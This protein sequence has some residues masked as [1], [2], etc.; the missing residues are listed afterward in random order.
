MVSC[1]PVMLSPS[2]GRWLNSSRRTDAS[3]ASVFRLTWGVA[4]GR[5]RGRAKGLRGSSGRMETGGRARVAA[6]SCHCAASSFMPSSKSSIKSVYCG[7][8][9]SCGAE[10]SLRS[11]GC[12]P[13]TTNSPILRDSSS[14]HALSS[15][16]DRSC[17][18]TGRDSEWTTNSP[19]PRDSWSIQFGVSGVSG[20]SGVVGCCVIIARAN[21]LAE[22][23]C[24][25]DCHWSGCGRVSTAV[26]D[27]IRIGG[28]P[29]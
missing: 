8:N 4:G 18:E 2:S 12:S 9:S 1:S 10:N 27:G 7:R 28:V 15:G 16:W 26:S 5:G 24:R 13:C 6:C 22:V 14:T 11:A 19:M 17:A 25:R 29:N 20:R 21:G 23:S 3:P